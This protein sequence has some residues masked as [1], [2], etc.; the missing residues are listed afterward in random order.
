MKDSELDFLYECPRLDP[1]KRKVEDAIENKVQKILKL[2]STDRIRDS[3]GKV[4]HLEEVN[5]L[6]QQAWDD[7]T[8]VELD[9]AEVRKARMTEIGYARKKKVWTKNTKRSGAGERLEDSE[10]RVDRYK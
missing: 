7:I 4:L 10:N 9:V 6:L 2:K 3:Q 5:D 8:G 1:P